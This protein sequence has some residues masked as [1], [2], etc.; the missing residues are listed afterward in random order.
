[1][2]G[3]EVF[4]KN[5]F[6][7]YD[8]SFDVFQALEGT[9]YLTC[10]SLI[11]LDDDDYLASTCLSFNFYTRSNFLLQKNKYMRDANVSKKTD[12]E[13]IED[14]DKIEAVF[15]SDYAKD[16]NRFILSNI[17]Q[18]CILFIDGPFVG[19]QMTSLNIAL[20]SEL[21]NKFVIPIFIVKNSSSNL[22][23]DNT[24]ELTGKYNSD[25]HWAYNYLSP[26][27]RT[28][29]FMY[30]DQVVSENCKVFCYI[31]P[32]PASPQRV[33]F[34]P[35]TYK[36]HKELVNQLI[37]VIYYF[38]LIQGDMKNSQIRPIVIAEKYARESKK[39][40]DL[41]RVMLDSTLQPTMNQARGFR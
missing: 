12:S 30:T 16:R 25:L 5:V 27:Q 21:L 38:Y 13:S 22:V 35:E 1:M 29:F 11:M 40:Y 37:D 23:T 36:K 32:F 10:H 19:K 14:K 4:G 28:N 20:N 8:E 2:N 3:I 7:A 15:K 41:N 18:N 33:E 24:A 26:G 17:P 31:K 34:H 39:M 6:L 9:G